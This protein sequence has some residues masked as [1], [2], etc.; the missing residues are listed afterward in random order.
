VVVGVAGVKKSK[1][2]YGYQND[3]LF[4]AHLFE[5]IFPK[6]KVKKFSDEL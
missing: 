2:Q 5:K 3:R 1:N 6:K 4:K